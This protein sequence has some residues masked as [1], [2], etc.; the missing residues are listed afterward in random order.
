MCSKCYREVVQKQEREKANEA[1]AAQAITESQ[2]GY[3]SA[4]KPAL[5]PDS[6]T[7]AKD[8][9]P[10]ASSADEEASSSG[11]A[12]AAAAEEVPPPVQTNTSRCW[13]CNKRIGL[14]GFKCRCGYVYCAGHRYAEKHECAYDY[15]SSGRQSITQQNPLV[16]ASKLQKF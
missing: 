6:P 7:P 12:A 4:V 5:K 10:K 16:Q 13:T 15:K 14:T 2:P 3:D 11:A 8:L 1:A 9:A